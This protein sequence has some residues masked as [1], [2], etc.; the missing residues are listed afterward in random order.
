M[1]LF[2]KTALCYTSRGA[3]AGTRNS[4]MGP[5]HEG[6]IRRPIA[7]WEERSYHG[8]TSRSLRNGDANPVP[9]SPLADDKTTAPLGPV[10]SRITTIQDVLLTTI[11]TVGV[12]NNRYTMCIK[13]VTLTTVNTPE[14]RLTVPVQV[15][16]ITNQVDTV[17]AEWATQA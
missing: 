1:D 4:S 11:V 14:C 3:L 10:I 6:S 9:T 17:E 15:L 2:K 13:R 8:A 7:P 5:P 12:T 16:H